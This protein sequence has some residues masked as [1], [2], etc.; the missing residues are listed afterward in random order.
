M[1]PGRIEKIRFKFSPQ[2]PIAEAAKICRPCPAVHRAGY[3]RWWPVAKG[4]NQFKKNL[5]PPNH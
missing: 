1:P 4:D 2:L 3:A 5:W